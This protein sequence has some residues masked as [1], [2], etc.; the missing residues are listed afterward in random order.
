MPSSVAKGNRAKSRTK[1]WL[2]AQGYAVAHMEKVHWIQTPRGRIGVKRD[3]FGCDLLGMSRENGLVFVQV[4]LG[5]PAVPKSVLA[6]QLYPFPNSALVHVWIVAW[7]PRA[8]QPL[9]ID[10]TGDVTTSKDPGR[11]I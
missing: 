5:S 7:K 10:V 6:F 11:W 4:K 2:E 3:Q 8:R 1:K 9:V